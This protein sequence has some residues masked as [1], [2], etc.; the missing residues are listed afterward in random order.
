MNNDKMIE[1][2]KKGWDELIKS[3]A[4]FSNTILPE[5]GPRIINLIEIIN[6]FD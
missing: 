6:L 4:A 2:N 5:Y 3:N 1:A